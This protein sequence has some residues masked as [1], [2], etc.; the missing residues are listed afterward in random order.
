MNDKHVLLKTN[1]TVF[2]T[3]LNQVILNKKIYPLVLLLWVAIYSG[4]AQDI[5]YSQFYNAPLNINPALTGVFGGDIRFMG[6]YRSQWRRTPVDYTTF[7]GAVDMKFINR[8]ATKGF[9]S[10]GL[11]FNYD[12]AGYSKLNLINLGLN[13]SYTRQL[14]N[15]FFVSFGAMVAANQRR[16]QTDDLT[17]DSGFDT[18]T[19]TYDPSLGSGESFSSTSRFFLDFGG[20]INFRLQGLD[21]AVMIDRLEKRSKLDFG[22]GVF[23]ITQPDQ[24]FYENYESPLTIRI[25]PYALGVVQLGPNLDAVANLVGQF[26]EPYREYLGMIGGRLYL[27]RKLG[28]QIAVQLGVGYRFSEFS[29]LSLS[30]DSYVPAIEVHY[31]QW[32]AGFSYDVNTSDFNV[33]TQKRGGPEFSIRYVLRKIRPLPYFK[34]CPLI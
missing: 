10:G 1:E 6:N 3:L 5:H 28:R 26:Q 17:F 27:S 32:R 9:F 23:H 7:T 13:G 25:A 30:R 14:S 19:G 12:Q 2:L 20:G 16:F 33:T 4:K 29:G 24:S 31:N 22:I 15:K 8:T 18:G 34:H 11:T 21:A